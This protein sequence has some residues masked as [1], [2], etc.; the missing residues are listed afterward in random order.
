MSFDQ[1]KFDRNHG[2]Q[3]VR[4][5]L[6]RFF[7]GKQQC[8]WF[9]KMLIEAGY[10]K[11]EKLLK[12]MNKMKLICSNLKGAVIKARAT[13]K[14]KPKVV[15]LVLTNFNKHGMVGGP[16]ISMAAST[17]FDGLM[18]GNIGSGRN[19]FTLARWVI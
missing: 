13:P 16:L 4:Y 3:D 9:E 1:R 14:P 11:D 10:R 8:P 2:R 7:A 18:K 6:R 12:S 17:K 19:A 5:V 15:A